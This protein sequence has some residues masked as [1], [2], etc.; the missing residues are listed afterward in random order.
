MAMNPRLLRPLAPRG[1]YRSLRVGLVAYWPFEEDASSGDVTAG[2]WTGRG[3]NL[4]SNNSV[5]SVTGKIGSGRG[6][7]A[8]N[9]EFLAAGGNNVDLRFADGRDWTLAGWIWV[10]TWTVGMI[11]A[12]RD[13]SSNREI[14]FD[15]RAS[16]GNNLGLFFNPGG[17]A[18]TTLIVGSSMATSTWHF[19]AWTYTSATRTLSGRVN[20]GVGANL[21]SAVH[22]AA[23]LATSVNP[24]RLGCRPWPGAESFLTGQL[25]EVAK[26]DRVLSQSELD[27]LWNN[28][29]GIDLRQ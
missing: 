19:V 15:L 23:T 24:L 29:T 28:G 3:N 9:S 7:T 6:F 11:W 26:W 13:N 4:S 17:A 22:P 1:R 25:D 18:S 8:T 27:T 2:D 5:P 14:L 16:S 20:N 21:G 12:G 10:P